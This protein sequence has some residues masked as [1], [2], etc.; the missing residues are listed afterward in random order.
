VVEQPA[1]DA[2]D[3]DRHVK[4]LE[5]ADLVGIE[6][7]RGHDLDRLAPAARFILPLWRDAPRAPRRVDGMAQ[8]MHEARGDAAVEALVA[9]GRH[10]DVTQVAAGVGPHPEQ[11]VPCGLLGPPGPQ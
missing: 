6:A 8:V 5:A 1:A 11:A 4:L 3:V 7:A 2:V 10:A 9:D